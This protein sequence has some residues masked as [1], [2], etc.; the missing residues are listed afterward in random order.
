MSEKIN[1]VLR[2][3]SVE[4]QTAYRKAVSEILLNIQND[5]KI[6]LHEIAEQI[7]VSLGTI[8]NAANRKNDLNVTF[9][10]RL[11]QV[12]GPATLDPYAALYGARMVPLV[13]RGSA[14]ILPMLG[15]ASLSI[16]EARDPASKGGS[17]ET[18]CERLGYLPHLRQLRRELDAVILDIEEIAA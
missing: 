1:K 15:R 11:G 17:T 18:H 9:L 8:S 13:A 14:D 10:K 12:Y 5:H 7:D 16:A 6:T 2:V 4:E 3:N